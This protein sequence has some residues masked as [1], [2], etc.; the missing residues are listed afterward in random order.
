MVEY[1]IRASDKIILV[2]ADGYHF[3]MDGQF[4]LLTRADRELPVA[5]IP[6]HALESVVQSQKVEFSV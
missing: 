1:M 3:D 4:L 5:I 6:T 2:D